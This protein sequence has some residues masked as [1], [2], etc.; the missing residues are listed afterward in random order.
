MVMATQPTEIRPDK[1]NQLS[2]VIPALVLKKFRMISSFVT[3]WAPSPPSSATPSKRL[4]SLLD[5]DHR[6]DSL[7]NGWITAR[8]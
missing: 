3:Q 5:H 8:T 7:E 4:I 2:T 1:L 6:T